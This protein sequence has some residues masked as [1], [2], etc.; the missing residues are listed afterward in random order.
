MTLTRDQVEAL[1]ALLHLAETPGDF[2]PQE[3]EDVLSDAAGV[4]YPIEVR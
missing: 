2:T 3:Q 4:L 1:R